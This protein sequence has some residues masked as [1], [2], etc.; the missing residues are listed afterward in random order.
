MLFGDG[1]RVV[2]VEINLG[3]I[4]SQKDLGEFDHK[5]VVG[6]KCV[7]RVLVYGEKGLGVFLMRF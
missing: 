5:D 3:E 2:F 4:M 6:M 1:S 7:G